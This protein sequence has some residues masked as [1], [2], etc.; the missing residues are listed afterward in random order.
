MLLCTGGH[1]YFALSVISPLSTAAYN[2]PENITGEKNI[3]IM[4]EDFVAS[5]SRGICHEFQDVTP[6]YL[7]NCSAF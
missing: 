6:L 2:K 1:T 3:L 4:G 7:E 5:P